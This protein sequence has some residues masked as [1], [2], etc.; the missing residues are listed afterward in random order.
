MSVIAADNTQQDRR[1]TGP[2]TIVTDIVRDVRYGSGTDISR[3]GFYVRFTP[4]NGRNQ[5]KNGHQ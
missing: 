2:Q 1:K 5:R 4:N 3:S